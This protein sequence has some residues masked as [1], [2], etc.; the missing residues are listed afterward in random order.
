MQRLEVSGA[1]RPLY[2][3]LGVKRLRI[4]FFTSVVLPGSPVQKDFRLFPAGIFYR[5]SQSSI[6]GR[7][8]WNLLVVRAALGRVVP[9]KTS[10]APCQ[11]RYTSIPYPFVR[12]SVS[13]R[14]HVY[15]DSA[16]HYSDTSANE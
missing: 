3:S 7:Y 13:Y 4:I 10:V 14:C 2:G 1:V 6:P 12:P 8:S 15:F 5:G 11:Y 9:Q 16:V